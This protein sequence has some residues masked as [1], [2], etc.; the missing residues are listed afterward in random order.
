MIYFYILFWQVFV[1]P[2]LPRGTPYWYRRY[3]TSISTCFAEAFKH[4]EDGILVL[5]TFVQPDYER[6]G[7]HLTEGDGPRY[8][9]M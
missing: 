5:P 3:F 9:L 1:V 6:D 2:P 7:I 8:R 4:V